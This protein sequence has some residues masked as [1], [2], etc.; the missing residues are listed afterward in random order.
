[1]K[2]TEGIISTYAADISGVCSALFELGGMTVMHDPSGCNSTYNTHDEPR[3]YDTDS[4]V[5][6][7]GLTEL[8][9]V[10]GDEEKHIADIVHTAQQ[11]KPKF[12][13]LAGSPIPM[14]M[15][16]DFKAMASVVERR[17]GIP[18]MG[19]STNGMHS[20][21]CG[22]SQSLQQLAQRFVNET[23]GETIADSVNILGLTP[24]DF[25][26]NGSVQ[27]IKNFLL[28]SGKTVLSSWCM[29][30][31]LEQIAQAGKAEVNLVVSYS[32]LQ[33]A[34]T[35]QRRFGTPYVVGAP[36]GEEFSAYVLEALRCAA[37]EKKNIIACTH[38]TES[39][40]GTVIIGESVTAGSMAA[41][42]QMQTGKGVSV[43]CPLETAPEL[44][45]PSDKKTPDEDEVQRQL[46]NASV[47]IADPLYRPVCPP[48]AR[49]IPLPSEA[50]SGRIFRKQI[51]DYT[52]K[53]IIF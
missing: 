17:T 19:I 46:Q 38:R 12:I 34:Q 15:G 41:A 14:I 42:L 51:V 36:Y 29:D 52:A 18:A 10:M 37:D 40:D 23:D 3:W 13:A 5:F 48:K 26:V 35:L 49:F 50:F 24:L 28:K 16:T 20:Y 45:L 44:L 33:A 6:I 21:L 43:L 53:K 27:S 2:Q 25:S 22:V 9:A 32:G 8:E 11:L 47:V 1:M 30:T 39:T 4:L 7:T 31:S